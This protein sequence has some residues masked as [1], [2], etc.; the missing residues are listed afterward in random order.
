MCRSHH[1]TN[2]LATRSSATTPATIFGNNT[3]DEFFDNNTGIFGNNTGNE[4]FGNNNTGNEVFG[5]N[6]GNNT[7]NRAS[8]EFL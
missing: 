6:T 4:V 7:G 8:R 2:T 3:S 5:N 1:G